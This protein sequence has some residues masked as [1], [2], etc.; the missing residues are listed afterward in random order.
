MH[1]ISLMRHFNN[2]LLFSILVFSWTKSDSIH[3]R[4][5]WLLVQPLER[6]L[7][8]SQ[9]RST[10]ARHCWTHKRTQQ[11]AWAMQLRKCT[12]LQASED[13]SRVY[14]H[15]FCIKCQ[16]QPSAGQPMNS[17]NTC[18]IELRRK[19]QLFRHSRRSF[20]RTTINHPNNLY[21]L[22]CIKNRRWASCRTLQFIQ[23]QH[24]HHLLC[25]IH[26]SYRPC[27]MV[28]SM[29]IRCTRIEHL[30]FCPI[31]ERHRNFLY[32]PSWTNYTPATISKKKRKTTNSKHKNQN[33]VETESKVMW[34]W[35]CHR[36]I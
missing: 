4:L 26:V 1:T 6:Q 13:S 16:R 22:F 18:W 28:S 21:T 12:E 33:L 9:H 8:H 36:F 25:H 31:F 7:L 30:Q 34:I 20:H 15:A 29:L 32:P 17:S 11:E 24:R 14:R 35:H 27:R 5:M 2:S 3:R 10:C 19:R 23:H